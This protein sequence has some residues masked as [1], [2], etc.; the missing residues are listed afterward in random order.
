VID[1]AL[2]TVEPA[3]NAKGILLERILDPSAAMVHGDPGRL[4]QIS[5]NLL[6]NAIKFTPRGGRVQVRLQRVESLARIS[7][8]DTGEGVRPEFLPYVFE[9]FRQ[10]DPSTKRRHGGLGLG[11]AIVKQLVELHGGTVRAYSEGENKGSTFTVE[12][13]LA[14]TR[15]ERARQE[16]GAPPAQLAITSLEGDDRGLIPAAGEP[17]SLGGVRVMVV[18]DE[19]DARELICRVLEHRNANVYCAGSAE[20]AL[21]AMQDFQPDVLV[22]DIGMPEK[23]GYELI[24]EVRSRSA[25]RGGATPAIA[26]TAFARTEDRT[27][28]LLAGYQMHVSKPVEPAELIASVASMAGLTGRARIAS[29]GEADRDSNGHDP[30][31]E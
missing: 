16:E 1:A 9:R 30:A 2:A 4:Q 25:D 20:E 8:T 5:W 12:L 28:A 14:S 15:P 31:S 6:S 18:E 22:S 17:L 10:A 29:K 23:D 13:P 21:N 3:A 11:L 26:L 27:R 7:V 19:P 24:R